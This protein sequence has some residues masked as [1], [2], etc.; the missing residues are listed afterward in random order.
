VLGW[1]FS[2]VALHLL[3]P[4]KRVQG[5]V[6]PDGSKLTYKLNAFL[7]FIITYGAAIYLGFVRN[8]LNLGY[9]YDAFLPLTT[10]ATLFSTALAVYLYASSFKKGAMLSSHGATGWPWYDFWMGREL[11]PRVGPLDLKE[12]C[13]LY[14]GLIGWALINLGMAHKQWTSLGRVTNSMVLVNVFQLY[15]VADALWNE[16]SILTTMDITTDGFGF[17]LSFG[18]LAWVPFVFT[19]GARYL[20][21]VPQDLPV[22]GVALVLGVK[23]LGY[24]VFRGAN[25]QKD[26]FRRDPTHPSVAHLKTLPT[27]RGTK[28]IISGWWGASRHINYFGDWIMGLSWCMPCGL[29]GLQSV[30]PYFYCIYF[31]SLLIHRERRDEAAC[32]AK[33]GADWDKYCKLVPYRIIPYVY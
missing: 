10:A 2:L 29:V 12:F 27:A 21:F 6:L 28:L 24:W 1:F 17:M 31:A 8:S 15:Y 26:Q 4:G 18:D 5:V 16:A 23:A 25:G 20:V 19:T 32:R 33:Y 9:L 7:L 14:P 13:E 11:N 22:W 30:I 3:L